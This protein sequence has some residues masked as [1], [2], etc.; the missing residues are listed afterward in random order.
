MPRIKLALQPDYPFTCDIQV[1]VGD[2]NYGGHVGNAEL[3]RIVHDARV[4]LFRAMGVR[5]GDLGDGKTGIITDDLVVNFQ[6]EAFLGDPLTVGCTFGEVGQ[7]GCRIHYHVTKA[8]KTVA[9]AETGIVAF[10]YTAR[11]VTF[12][13][14]E[15]K[16][17]ATALS[18]GELA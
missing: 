2:L 9:M 18:R 16:Q 15:F 10:N 7:A 12:W 4:E 17:Q 6:S 14:R 1:R 3:V 11:S 8:G 13:P 5:E